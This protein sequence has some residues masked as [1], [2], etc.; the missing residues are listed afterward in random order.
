LF[1]LE[2]ITLVMI[3]IILNTVAFLLTAVSIL[4]GQQTLATMETFGDFG[5][6][7][8]SMQTSGGYLYTIK[9]TLP[10]PGAFVFVKL[11]KKLNSL[12]EYTLPADHNLL[13][14]FTLRDTTIIYFSKQEYGHEVYLNVLSMKTGKLLSTK[15]SFHLRHGKYVFENKLETQ[16]KVY[17]VE[18]SENPD[19]IK[20]LK[21][22][23]D[24]KIFYSAY[25]KSNEDV[26]SGEFSLG[27][28]Y[29]SLFDYGFAG[30]K[31]YAAG[32]EANQARKMGDL[33]MY[34]YDYKAGS[35]NKVVLMNVQGDESKCITSSFTERGFQCVV[36]TKAGKQ[37]VVNFIT[38][39]YGTQQ[40]QYYNL[41][42]ERVSES[43]FRLFDSDKFHGVV[44]LDQ[45]KSTVHVLK[46]D[47]QTGNSIGQIVLPIEGKERLLSVEMPHM[48]SD[49]RMLVNVEQS[50]WN[51]G[52][53]R[54]TYRTKEINYYLLD[55]GCNL[56]KNDVIEK[57]RTSM[58][59]I[60]L[61]T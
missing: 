12:W 51:G 44:Y 15:E 17:Y 27:I 57:V 53:G 2:S 31:I 55:A 24:I 26:A 49:D 35:L 5:R 19:R 25:D 28:K 11:D 22:K 43:G 39:S 23:E 46:V 4:Y 9:T 40:S 52:N 47:S 10:A 18:L 38:F 60:E 58:V 54:Y 30:D 14:H 34:V 7:K 21:N 37:D 8:L 13:S 3:K 61:M 41:K 59:L 48:L 33:V 1:I 6:G 50:Y 56:M 29:F 42:G 16:G 45:G 20:D 32:F 36:H